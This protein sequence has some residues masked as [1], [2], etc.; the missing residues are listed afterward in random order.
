V[1]TV[2]IAGCGEEGRQWTEQGWS[3][4]RLDIDPRTKPDIVG[5]MTD[6]GQ[7]GPFDAVACNNA[8]EHLYPHEVTRALSEFHRV[9]APGGRVVI[10]VPDL[11]DV[12]ATEDLI[13]EIGMSGLHLFYGEEFPYMAHHSGFVEETLRRVMESAGF[14]VITKRL[15]CHQLMGIGTK[16]EHVRV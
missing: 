12:K 16:Y 5:T 13:P 8:L 7:I 2:L 11:Q 15:T 9:L 4:V 10:Q 1:P 3:V 14:E 6:L